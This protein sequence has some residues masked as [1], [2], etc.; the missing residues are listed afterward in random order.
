MQ[1]DFV[2]HIDFLELFITLFLI[3]NYIFLNLKFL[4]FHNFPGIQ[5][6]TLL[7]PILIKY[8]LEPTQMR[9]S[10]KYCMQLHDHALQWLMKIGPK[11]PLVRN[12][13]QL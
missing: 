4:F 10:S 7:V 3:E 1:G 6:L 8:L 11:Y 9:N 2:D 5:M 12:S 13:N